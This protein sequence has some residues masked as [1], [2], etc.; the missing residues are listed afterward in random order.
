MTPLQLNLLPFTF[1]VSHSRTVA[2]EA[3]A[4]TTSVTGVSGM[5]NLM[6][7]PRWASVQ[8]FCRSTSFPAIRSSHIDS[9]TLMSA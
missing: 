8:S 3:R 4:L 5:K 9:T 7:A 2:A 6:S 1:T